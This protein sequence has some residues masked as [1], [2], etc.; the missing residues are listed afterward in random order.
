MQ[1]YNIQINHIHAMKTYFDVFLYIYKEIFDALFYRYGYENYLLSFLFSFLSL[2]LSIRKERKSEIPICFFFEYNI[3]YL[4]REEVKYQYVFS[5]NI[6]YLI[7]RMKSYD[8]LIYF[9]LKIL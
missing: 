1:D 9:S 6:I 8:S 5:L 7:Y 2:S 3:P 4:S